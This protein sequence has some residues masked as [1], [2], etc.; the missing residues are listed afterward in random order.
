[1]AEAAQRAEP[2]AQR[3]DEL[4]LGM[5]VAVVPVR[6]VQGDAE[7]VLPRE[8]GRRL[9]GGRMRLERQRRL[10]GEHLEQERERLAPLTLQERAQVALVVDETA[11]RRGVAAEPEL[12]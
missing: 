1:R 7:R 5:R 11:R 8:P 3:D 9:F 4:R 10:G 2:V 6:S 12:G